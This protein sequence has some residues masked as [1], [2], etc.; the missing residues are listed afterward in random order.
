MTRFLS[1]VIALLQIF[2]EMYMWKNF[3]HYSAKI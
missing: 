2:Y 3:E 1:V